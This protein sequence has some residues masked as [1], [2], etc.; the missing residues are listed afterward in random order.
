MIRMLFSLAVCFLLFI[1]LANLV[2]FVMP[3]LTHPIA[4][5][6]FTVFVVL[7]VTKLV[8]RNAK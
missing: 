3:V 2:A 4:T 7:V 8:L 6:F 5:T 1:L